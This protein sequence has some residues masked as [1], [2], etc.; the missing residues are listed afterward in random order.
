MSVYAVNGKEPI[1]AW[2]PSRDTAGNGTT[3]LND[4]VG[5]NTGTLT[6]MDAGTD[7]VSDTDAGGVRALDFDGSNDYVAATSGAS[8]YSQLTI[9]V[10][11]KKAA[12]GNVSIVSL[13]NEMSPNRTHIN[14]FTDSNVY[15]ACEDGAGNYGQFSFSY[16]SGWH[17]FAMVFDGSASG[18]ANRLKL[19]IDG[20][21]RTLSFVGTV[22]ATIVSSTAVAIGRGNTN[23][24]T[25][26]RIDDLRLWNQ[27]LAAADVAALYSSGLGRGILSVTGESRRRRQSVSGGVL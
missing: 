10:W 21:N 6:N 24:Y 4:L 20:V 5:S 19:W 26:G 25:T 7:W 8:G 1:A 23:F 17:H 14:W 12:S 13:G 18:N 22:P 16:V 9:S 27:S 15:L 3:T 2:I 11:M